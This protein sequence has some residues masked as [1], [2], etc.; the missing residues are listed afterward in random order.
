LPSGSLESIGWDA[1]WAAAFT[2]HAAHGLEPAR[3]SAEHRDQYEILTVQGAVRAEITGRVRFDARDPIALPA[4]GDWVAIERRAAADG[5]AA[6][7]HAVVPRRS[8]FVRRASGTEL[9]AQT[10]A[11]NVDV[12]FVATSLDADFSPRRLE[13]YLS[14]GWESGST[15]V[16]VL[17]KADEC[18]ERERMEG[19]ALVVAVGAQ[20]IVTS[21]VTGEGIEALREALAGTRTGALLG[22]SG[23]GKSTLINRLLGEE[24]LKTASVREGDQKG[25]HTTTHRQ[26]VAVPGGGLLIDTPGMRE[27]QLWESGAGVAAAFDD[28]EAMAANCR[29]RDCTHTSE[30]ECAVIAAVSDGT[31]SADRLESWHK[32][33]RELAHLQRKIDP[34]AKQAADREAKVANRNM[35]RNFPGQGW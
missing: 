13:R 26:L 15:P 19:E 25:R 24:R 32:L 6:T 16:V 33:Q 28:V 18:E 1:A 11:A 23:V 3:V 2:S 12:V 9:R 8:Q 4:V 29:F 35:R 17:T 31:L 14:L 22:S 21:A 5:D 34:F 10:V 27:L 20:V 30:P 7:I